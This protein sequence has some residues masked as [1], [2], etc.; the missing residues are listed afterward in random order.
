LPAALAVVALASSPPATAAWI[1]DGV[2]LS[3]MPVPAP[4]YETY[5]FRGMTSDG[6]QGAYVVW[7]FTSWRPEIDPTHYVYAAQ[8]VDVLGNRPARWAAAGA[9]LIAFDNT[10]TFGPFAY[11]PFKVFGDGAGGATVAGVSSEF[12]VEPMSLFRLHH[13]N[14]GGTAT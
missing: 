2:P 5:S 14:P 4:P 13:V 1:P 10:N 6:A 8:R 12:N 7:E 11:T 9:S 3:P